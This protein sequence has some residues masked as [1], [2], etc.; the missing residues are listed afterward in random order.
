M[1]FKEAAGLALLGFSVLFSQTPFRPPA[2]PLV[3][4]DP[5]FSIWSM[6]DRLTDESTKHWT[7]VNQGMCALLRVDGR[8]LRLMGPAPKELPALPQTA[9]Q[10]MPTQTRY[11][12]TGEGVQVVMTFTTP[13]LPDDLNLLSRPITFLTFQ[14][15][16][17]DSGEHDVQLYFD[18]SMDPAVNE[19]KQKAVWSRLQTNELAVLCAGSQE[20]P[21]LAKSGDNL[22]IDWGYYYLAAEWGMKPSVSIQK[23]ALCRSSFEKSGDLPTADDMDMPCAL[24]EDAPV[25]AM[26][27]ALGRVSAIIRQRYLILA[28]D[29]QYS[30]EYFQRKLRPYW[31]RN[32][33][34]VADLLDH[35]C[36][37]YA[38]I[39]NRC[40]AFDRALFNDL[41][42]VGGH[43]YAQLASLAY[44][45][46]LAAQKL[47]VDIDGRPLLFP[48][49]NFSNG[50]I[51]TVDVIYPAAP[52]LLL[53]NL[54][55]MKASVRPV[56]EYASLA[57][58]KFPFA[59]H[60]LGTYPKANGQVYGGGEL[61]EENQMPV[62]ES[63]NM[64]LLLAAIAQVEG[65]ADFSAQYWPAVKKWACYLK[66]KGLDPENQ[67]CTDD[68]AG[69]LA[70]NV[71]LSL[72][73]ILA[74]AAYSRLCEMRDLKP[75]ADVFRKLSVEYAHKW[76]EMAQEDD[77]YRLAFDKPGTWSQKYNLV[78]DQILNL[79][80][81]PKKVAQTEVRWYLQKQHRYGLPLDSRKEY[82]KLDWTVWTATLAESSA[83]FQAL[84]NP[85]WL[86]AH[87][88]GSRVPLSDWYGTVDGKMVGFQARSVVGGV[89][90]KMLADP[91]MWKKWV[92]K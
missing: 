76:I 43:E 11:E 13:L 36:S 4:I 25:M 49:E 85:V 80:V 37:N 41:T 60:D 62:E 82:T 28:Y 21:V 8:T 38:Y 56:L 55:L 47:A 57:R 10:V 79:Q 1:N 89:F 44:R 45:Q 52:Q 58:W 23:A 33:A 22:R 17:T 40:A 83:D 92:K 66:E 73:A 14:V 84:V 24:N 70:H 20:Q 87:E 27:F 53:F 90:V 31:R 15:C 67:L 86:F 29:D 59:P 71:N 88:T 30:I 6:Q 54:E 77:H 69:H 18:S 26:Q 72:K 16:A 74:M 63:G 35:A 42:V 68:F 7:G 32:G 91:V 65:N 19:R 64:L 50:C 9:L 48:K 5:Y 51:A 75:E 2:T 34:E 39:M 81:F 46:G 78:W 61:T 3:C 12:F